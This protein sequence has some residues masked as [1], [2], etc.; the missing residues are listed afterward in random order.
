MRH[1]VAAMVGM[2]LAV[3]LCTPAAAQWQWVGK[4]KKTNFSDLPPPPGTPESDIIQRP[5]GAKLR[6]A[7]P[8]A[9]AASDAAASSAS[10][11][12]AAKVVEPEL[13]AKLRKEEQ[14]KAA[15][16]KAD[17]D[18]LAAQKA[19]NCSRAKSQLRVIDEGLRIARV[20]EKGEREVLD[21]TGRAEEA[22]RNRAVIASDCK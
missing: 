14:E 22:S 9:V 4:D 15:K 19:D 16:A 8:A 12:P 18:K 20:N 6:K 17:A 2:V 3:S 7:P 21:D 5:P 1:A 13:E 10:A 11:L